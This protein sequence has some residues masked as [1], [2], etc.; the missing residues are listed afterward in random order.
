MGFV[1]YHPDPIDTSDFKAATAAMMSIEFDPTNMAATMRTVVPAEVQLARKE[2]AAAE[3]AETARRAKLSAEKK[4]KAL[5]EVDAEEAEM[6]ED[7]AKMQADTGVSQL[8]AAVQKLSME[9]P[10]VSPSTSATPPVSPSTSAATESP[11]L[12]EM[13]ELRRE[14]SLMKGFIE[15]QSLMDEYLK[16]RTP[17][18]L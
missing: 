5:M 6:A 9:D 3:K 4:K 10:S 13:E 8:E 15:E 11:A 1:K 2:A 12:S 14:V 7:I 18:V 16:Y 17:D